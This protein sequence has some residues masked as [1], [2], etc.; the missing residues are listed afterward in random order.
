MKKLIFLLSFVALAV[1]VK[2]QVN[3]PKEMP[4]FKILKTD[5][6]NYTPANLPKSKAV[7]IVYFSPDCTHCQ[8]FTDGLLKLIDKEPKKQKDGYRK[9]QFVMITYTF[10]QSVQM[11]YADYELAKYPNF[12]VGTE[13]YGLAVQKFYQVKTTPYIAVYNKKRELIKAFDKVPAFK[14]LL[15]AVK[16]A[17]L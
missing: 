7:V 5:S 16:E 10:L 17:E 4:P 13:G 12:V 9:A 6:T 15:V 2:A 14:D 1:G 8:H 3:P 11:F